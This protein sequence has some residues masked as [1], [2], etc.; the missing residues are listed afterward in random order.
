MSFEQHEALCE[1]SL[2]EEKEIE[3]KRIR[4]KELGSVCPYVDCSFPE[5]LSLCPEQCAGS[6]Y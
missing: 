1:A 4:K 5:T 2:T 3:A 6:K